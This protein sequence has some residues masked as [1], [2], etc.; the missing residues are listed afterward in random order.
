[1]SAV[2]LLLI[3]SPEPAPAPQRDQR[4]L[5]HEIGEGFRGTFSNPYLRAFAGE[6]VLPAAKYHVAER[7]Q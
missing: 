2:G 7:H 3:R 4:S 5:V 1:V 6:L